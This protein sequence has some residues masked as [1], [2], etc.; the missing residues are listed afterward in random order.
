MRINVLAL[1]YL[2][3]NRAQPGYGIFVLSRLKAV[4]AVCNIKVVAPVQWYPF[5]RL[6]RGSLSSAEVPHEESIDGLDVVHPRFAVIPRYMKW[7]DALSFWWSARRA[8]ARLRRRAAFDFDLVDVHWTY[9]DIVAAYFIAR[10]AHKKFIV[11]IRGHEALYDTERTIR[12]WLVAHYLRRADG[13]VALSEELRDKVVKLGVDPAKA[14]VI[15]NGVETTRFHHIEQSAAR[16]QLGLPEH[17]KLLLSVGRL[18]AGK[19]HQDLIRALPGLAAEHD[20]KLCI[21]G[22]I[23]PEADYR[24][25]LLKLI[26]E[27]GLKNVELM[28]EVGHTTLP[29]WYAA[30]DVFCL[31]TKSEG[32]PNV[33]L[34]ALACG[35][36]AVV[37]RVGAVD[38]LIKS[39][40]NGCLVERSDPESLVKQLRIALSTAWNR[41]EIAARMRSKWGWERCAEQVTDLYRAVLQSGSEPTP[42]RTI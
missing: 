40:E 10:V 27:L 39:G 17:G 22:G 21:I 30:A 26:E 8:V 6:L 23:N 42:A 33:V 37:S 4:R 29:L 25:T 38:E 2:F 14:H 3:P 1:S 5:M 16:R 20:V 13:V 31:A 35:T 15:L 36:P 9:P 12:R 18:T 24:P 28:D 34:E 41:P 32:C 7:F 11:T 19:G